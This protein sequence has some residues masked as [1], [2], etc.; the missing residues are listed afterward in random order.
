MSAPVVLLLLAAGCETSYQ[1]PP[2]VG[3]PA[4]PPPAETGR[5]PPPPPVYPTPEPWVNVSISVPERQIIQGYVAARDVEA[6]HPKKGK[7]AKKLPPGLQKKVER[8]GSLPPGWEMKLRRGEILPVEV[9][10]HCNPLPKQVMVQL[11]PQPPGTVLVV[12]G[13]KV[14]RLLAAT[15]EILDVFEV[16]R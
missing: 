16:V 1:P 7:K 14:A 3:Y 12:I 9:Y 13:G 4:P 2:V 11:P 6:E 5:R 8:G 10:Q 15:R